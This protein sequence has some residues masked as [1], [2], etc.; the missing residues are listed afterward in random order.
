MIREH[1]LY[2]VIL[3][4]S[5]HHYRSKFAVKFLISTIAHPNYAIAMLD[6]LQHVDK[7]FHLRFPSL[8]IFKSRLS[9][10]RRLSLTK[11]YIHRDFIVTSL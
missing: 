11:L 2:A 1:C 10:G 3:P 4:L 9:T 7:P 5:V 6:T 8:E